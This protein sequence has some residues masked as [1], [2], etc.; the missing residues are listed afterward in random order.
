MLN[1]FFSDPIYLAAAQAAVAGAMALVMM[2]I[3]SLAASIWKKRSSS[4]WCGDWCRW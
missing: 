1:N 3:A 2:V 4:H